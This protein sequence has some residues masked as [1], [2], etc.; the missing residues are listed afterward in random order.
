M[1]CQISQAPFLTAFA[2]YIHQQRYVINRQWK[3]LVRESPDVPDALHISEKAL[4]DHVPELLGDLVERL[5]EEREVSQETTSDHSRSHG[6]EQ[7]KAGYNISELI[8]EIYIIKRVL[9]QS[10][11]V[12]FARLHP[13]YPTGECVSAEIV[14]SDFF[15][16]LTCDSVGQFIKEQQR[17]V[18]EKNGALEKTNQARER[19]TRT[20]SHELRNVLNALTLATTMLGEEATAE[21]RQQMS[22]V[23]ARMLADMSTILNDLLDFSALIAGRAQL[24]LARLSL[25]GLF[26]EIT[27]QWRPVAREQ[28]MKFACQCDGKLGEIVSDKLKLARIAGNL[29]ANAVKYR[30]PAPGGDISVTFSAVG[31]AGWKLIVADT[32]IGIAREDL[33]SLFGEFNRI[34]PNSAVEGTGLGL[35]ICKEYA[36]LL[37]GRID[38]FSEPE[39]GTR[40]EVSLPLSAEVTTTGEAILSPVLGSDSLSA[41]TLPL[42][43]LPAPEMLAA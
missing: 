33:E 14:I 17:V 13:E 3:L 35:A 5:R 19:L 25:P 38:V 1:E 23:C 20:V 32:G 22:A 15:H 7:W 16:R 11:L 31:S 18:Q 9:R 41:P 10:V 28:G 4:E 29:L 37:G 40:F 42:A 43:P 2:D 24:T 34:R 39:Q 30:K 26:E 8:W 36:E 27:A 6:R 21:E 12:E